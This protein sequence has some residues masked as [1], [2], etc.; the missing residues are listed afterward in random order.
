MQEE[1]R[2]GSKESRSENAGEKRS[3]R[4]KTKSMLWDRMP[5]LPD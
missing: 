4:V 5:S 1:G 2:N 3:R